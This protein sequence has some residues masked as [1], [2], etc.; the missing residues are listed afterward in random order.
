M[1]PEDVR[2]VVEYGARNLEFCAKLY[3][4]QHDNGLYFLHEHPYS[5][6]S[7][8]NHYIRALL[9]LPGISKVNPICARLGWGT[10]TVREQGY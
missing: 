5:A 7:W 10:A 8:N 1:S 9:E 4:L 6:S 2:K 3:K